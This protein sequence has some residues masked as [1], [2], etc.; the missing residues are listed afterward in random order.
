M[1]C[2][3]CAITIEKAL[4]PLDDISNPKGNFSTSKLTVDLKSHNNINQVAHTL[5]KLGYGIE[6]NDSNQNYTTFLIKGMD[7]GSCTKSI[8]KHLNTLSYVNDAQ[9]SFSTGKMQVDFEGNQ[10]KNIENEVSKIGYSAISQS[11]N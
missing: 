4:N 6:E 10:T 1:D 2:S 5:N 11:S 8:E 7:C 3:A 9:V